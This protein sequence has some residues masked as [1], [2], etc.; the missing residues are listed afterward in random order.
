MT[1]T[2]LLVVTLLAGPRTD[3]VYVPVA[4][5]A[6]LDDAA[7]TSDELD[8]IEFVAFSKR[9][10]SENFFL[11]AEQHPWRLKDGHLEVE[12]SSAWERVEWVERGGTVYSGLL[13]GRL[14]RFVK[15]TIEARKASA[16][17]RFSRA[18]LERLAGTWGE[19]EDAITVD[20]RGVVVRGV[21]AEVPV[22]QCTPDCDSL[23]VRVCLGAA[24]SPV[25]WVDRP[26]GLLAV[27]K[28]G[29]GLCTSYV[30]GPETA[31]GVRLTRRG[32]PAKAPVAALDRRR[33]LAA[34]KA[35]RGRLTRCEVT[36]KAV[37]VELHVTVGL[38]GLVEQ[39]EAGE[40][41]DCVAASLS[42]LAFPPQPAPQTFTFSWELIR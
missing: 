36:G 4:D 9:E 22:T 13:G 16:S 32:V 33:V 7:A 31:G 12:R 27:K 14:F 41:S 2:Y 40:L 18:Q 21:R 34:L 10:V 42:R 39:V 30:F 1:L 35:R 37:K 5:A 19:G 3:G 8:F 25:M 20:A 38:S 29:G 24:D 6:L 17:R 26:D 28:A 11:E 15:G 23:F